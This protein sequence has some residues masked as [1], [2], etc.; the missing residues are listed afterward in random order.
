MADSFVS[1]MTAVKIYK[2]VSLTNWGYEFHMNTI[3]VVANNKTFG[4]TGIPLD[5]FDYM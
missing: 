4:N 1:K 3:N 2:H 5:C